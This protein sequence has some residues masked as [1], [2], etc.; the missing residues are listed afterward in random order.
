MSQIEDIIAQGAEIRAQLRALLYRHEYPGNTKNLVLTPYV[1]IAL[2][3][4]AA[5]WLLI[6]SKLRGSAFAMVRLGY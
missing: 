3:H 1:D 5:I 6:K 4:H 2:E